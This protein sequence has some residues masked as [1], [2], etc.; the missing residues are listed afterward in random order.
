MAL[1]APA[2][3]HTPGTAIGQAV[4]ALGEVPVSYTNGAV[5]SELEADAFGRLPGVGEDIYVAAL[6]ASVLREQPGGPSAVAGEIA[7]EAILHGTVVVVAGTK[8]GAWSDQIPENRLERLVRIAA[9]GRGDP[10]TRAGALVLAVDA[11]PTSSGGGR[12]WLVAAPSALLVAALAFAA[13]VLLR[14]RAA[15][16]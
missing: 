10:A 14:R 2:S 13:Y 6:P 12:L 7:R 8:L 3:A 16:A 1:A 5:V 11:E 15:R 4:L 9:S